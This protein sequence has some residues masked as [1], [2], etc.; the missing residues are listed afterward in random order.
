[1]TLQCIILGDSISTVECYDAIVG[2]WQITE[3]MTTLRSRV[4]VAVLKGKFTTDG[5]CLVYTIFW[6]KGYTFQHNT[7]VNSNDKLTHCVLT[8]FRLTVCDR[9]I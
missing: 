5:K 7:R 8:V 9:R 6:H 3:A 4:G 2:R 1:M